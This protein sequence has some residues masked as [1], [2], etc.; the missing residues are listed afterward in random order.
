MART[1]K[2]NARTAA[3]NTPQGRIAGTMLGLAERFGTEER[4]EAYLISLKYPDGFVC[5]KCGC[6]TEHGIE[7]RREH[8]CTR[9]G[10]QFSATSGTT[11]AH[12]KVPLVKWF[13]LGWQ[14]THGKRGI[15]AME[16]AEIAGV[17]DRCAVHM[18]QRMRGAMAWSQMLC[19]VGG[20][21]QLDDAYVSAGGR[22][23]GKAGRGT[24]EVPF[25]VAV[26]P[27]R[28]AVRATSDVSGGTYREFASWHVS[29]GASVSADDWSGIGAGLA[30]WDGLVRR[31]FDEGD[32]EASLP[33]AH[34]AISNLKA[35]VLGTHHGVTAS[36]LQEYCDQFSWTYN[37]R[38]GD[39]FADLL[40]DMVRW[41]H[42][43]KRLLPAVM[44][45]QPPGGSIRNAVSGTNW[46][47]RGK[48]VSKLEEARKSLLNTIAAMAQGLLPATV[49]NA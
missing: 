6:R 39:A 38:G 23:G 22:M 44:A 30:G 25:V 7:G 10:W 13:Q 3:Q 1:T 41:P 28:M 34:H 45:V 49:T 36:H 4:C 48:V 27:T 9:C 31:A 29:R 43:P 37:H 35:V 11:M 46:C 32:A 24:S 40:A 16:G 12:T 21:V 20:P 14:L 18:L 33:A 42:T 47:L 5:P 2:S 15:S 19:R 17:S 26:S 8:Q